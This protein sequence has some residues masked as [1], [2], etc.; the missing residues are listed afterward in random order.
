MQNFRILE[1]IINF[2]SKF[3][4]CKE[5][6]EKAFFFLLYLLKSLR[7][8]LKFEFKINEC[9]KNSKILDLSLFLNVLSR[10]KK[11]KKFG[12]RSSNEFTS[13]KIMYLQI[14]GWPG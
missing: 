6:L 14:Y 8:D 3:E 7:C 1:P 12:N 11:K 10:K 5:G 9:A 4:I 2:K 13:H